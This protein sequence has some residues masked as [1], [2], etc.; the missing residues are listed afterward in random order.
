MTTLPQLR[1]AREESEAQFQAA[2]IAAGL[3]IEQLAAVLGYHREV[4]AAYAA[5]LSI[6]ANGT[7][8]NPQST[9]RNPQFP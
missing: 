1:A 5:E 7:L 3:P 9:I 8:P 2:V 4:C 6:V